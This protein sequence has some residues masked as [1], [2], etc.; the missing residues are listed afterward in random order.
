MNTELEALAKTLDLSAESNRRLRL[1]FGYA[2]VSR[3]SQNL[4]EPAAIQAF[5]DFGDY[6]DGR[7][8]ETVFN[9][10]AESILI[11]ANQHRG[12]NSI[13]GS[14]HAAVSVTYALARAMNGKALDAASY[15]AYSQV[16]GYGGYA[17]NDPDAFKEEF[18]AQVE[19]LRMLAIR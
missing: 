18:C 3:V 17:V 7:L 11:I 2:C 6:L 15:A 9:K 1:Q 8:S 5:E 19:L 12:S 10:L 4:E 14:K 13:D 16:Y